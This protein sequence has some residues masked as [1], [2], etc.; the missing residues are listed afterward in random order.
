MAQATAN[1]HPSET[2]GTLIQLY[3]HTSREFLFNQI[4][5]TELKIP[6]PQALFKIKQ[7]QICPLSHKPR[8]PRQYRNKPSFR[9]GIPFLETINRESTSTIY[10]QLYIHPYSPL[11]TSLNR[12]ENEISFFLS[13]FLSPPLHPFHSI[14]PLTHPSTKAIRTSSLPPSLKP[15]P[16]APVPN[17][18]TLDLHLPRNRS[19][20]R[21]DSDSD[22]QRG[23]NWCGEILHAMRCCTH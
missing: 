23:W 19:A 9:S 8:V 5:L 22:A 2:G 12:R 3:N 10:A 21:P 16:H 7:P 18:R 11:L 17:N 6:L 1:P 14:L 4:Y 15:N 20:L 13:F